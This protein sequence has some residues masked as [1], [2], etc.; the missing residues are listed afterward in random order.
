MTLNLQSAIVILTTQEGANDMTIGQAD[1][2][3]YIQTEY[4]KAKTEIIGE[5]IVKI[6]ENGKSKDLSMNVFGD[7]LELLPYKKNRVIAVSDLPHN[8]DSLPLGARPTLWTK[9]DI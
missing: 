8:L 6:T 4:P 3:R 1:I 9:K 7:I 5:S 2:L